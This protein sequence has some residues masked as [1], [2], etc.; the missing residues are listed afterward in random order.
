MTH[1]VLFPKSEVK[2]EDDI[3]QTVETFAETFQ[4]LRVLSYAFNS[5]VISTDEKTL[6]TL[7]KHNPTWGAAKQGEGLA[8]IDNPYDGFDDMPLS[9]LQ[10]RIE[11]AKA[12]RKLDK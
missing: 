7:L 9:E 1:Y 12:R 10:K 8:A 6:D 3:A 4:G 2:S 5:A 11:T